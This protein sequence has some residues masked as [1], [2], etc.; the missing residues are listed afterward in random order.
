MPAKPGNVV[1]GHFRAGPRVVY[2]AEGAEPSVGTPGHAVIDLLQQALTD[3]RCGNL[4]FVAL[5]G[6]TVRGDVQP[7]WAGEY[8]PLTCLA[9][10]TDLRLRF[11]KAYLEATAED[12]GG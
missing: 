4:T 8:K 1:D 6:V 9:A 10:V 11:E 5:T 3:A 12:A 2:D 7:A